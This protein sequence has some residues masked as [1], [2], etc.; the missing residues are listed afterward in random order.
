M[1]EVY[2]L[3]HH[4]IFTVSNDMFLFIH[5][6]RF[7]EYFIFYFVLTILKLMQPWNE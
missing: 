2:M 5:I 7:H 1:F 3:F 4:Y 6:Y